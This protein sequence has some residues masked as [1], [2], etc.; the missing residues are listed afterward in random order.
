ML[1]EDLKLKS[2]A[3]KVPVYTS[4]PIVKPLDLFG[5]I[6]YEHMVQYIVKKIDDYKVLTTKISRNKRNKVQKKEI[7]DVI[8][9]SCNIGE[10]PA[11]L[12]KVSAYNTNLFDGY[13]E[14]DKKIELKQNNKLGSDNNFFLLYPVIRGI[15]INNYICQWFILIYEDP[16]KESA[17]I[18]NTCKLV[19]NKILQISTAN[20][21]LPYVLDEL[22]RVGEVPEVR[23]RLSSISFDDNEVDVKYR[24]YLSRT[25]F[26]KLK[27]ESFK[28]MPFKKTSDLIDDTSYEN[29][30][31]KREV[32][33]GIGNKEFKITQEQHN[34][35]AESVNQ[36]VEEIFNA[37]IGISEEEMGYI[38]K[39]EFVVS[40]LTDVLLNYLS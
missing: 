19:I 14:I 17:E 31:Q 18:I 30:F 6:T 26:R 20:I 1:K 3:I 23:I 2:Y 21:K 32:K 39:P 24:S 12:I 40:K 29:E 38:Y 36:I 37:T 25:K 7:D 22:K 35:A 16:N 34:D 27:E 15:D 11:L 13:V 10:V 4:E 8:H 9:I 28:N 5:G 33:I